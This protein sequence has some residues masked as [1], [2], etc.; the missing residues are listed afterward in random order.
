MSATLSLPQASK[1]GILAMLGSGALLLGALYFQFVEGLPPCE[2]CHWQRY[3]H[4]AAVALG[5]LALAA[6]RY[7]SVG[8][9]LVLLAIVAL[10]ATAGIGIYHVGVE[11][12]WWKG[13]DTCTGTIPVGLSVE[14]LKKYL[15]GAKMIRCDET[16]WSL[17]G[18]SMAG[19]NAILS[20]FLAFVMGTQVGKLAART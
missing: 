19:W 11:Y 15:F 13:P 4:I 3:P 17:W 12:R 7:P 5:F 20:L 6:Y 14:Q 18:V 1:L 9:V 10:L 2:L 16:A 8:L